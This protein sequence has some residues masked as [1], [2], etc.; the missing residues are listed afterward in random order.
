MDISYYRIKIRSV[1]TNIDEFCTTKYEI[2]NESNNK[3]IK[4]IDQA[5]FTSELFPL[6]D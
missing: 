4:N 5:E 3:Y 2:N 6:T 1:D